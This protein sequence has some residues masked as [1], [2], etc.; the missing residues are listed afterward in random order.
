LRRFE[1]GGLLQQPAE[2]AAAKDVS[3]HLDA[4]ML[5]GPLELAFMPRKWLWLPWLF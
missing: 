1:G 2:N 4:S 3:R 5:F